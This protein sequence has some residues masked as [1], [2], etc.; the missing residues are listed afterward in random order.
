MKTKIRNIV[1]VLS[2]C[3]MIVSYGFIIVSSSLP[4]FIKD[5]S[6]VKINYNIYPFDFRMNINEY[7]FYI[8]SKVADNIKNG[9]VKLLN[10]IESKVYNNTSGIINRTSEVFKS[11]GGKNK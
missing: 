3:L 10:N 1:L 2:I 11:V 9:S 4:K 7:S 5:R 6:A 8:N